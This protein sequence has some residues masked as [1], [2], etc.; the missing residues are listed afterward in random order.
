MKGSLLYD[1]GD[2]LRLGAS[3]ASEDETDLS[4]VNINF[5]LFDAFTDGYLK[6]VKSIIT[7]EEI[8][9]IL[10]GYFIMTFEVGMRF[11]TDFI[12]GDKYF[13]L[14]DNLKETR[15]L[16]NLE[17]AK[18]QLKLAKEIDDNYEKLTQIINKILKNLDYNIIIE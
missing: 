9:H 16:I 17:R 2:A 8:T 18:N 6:E 10:D 15:P 5:D 3:T 14:S 1:Y 13:T 7:D 12:D 4:K 11:L